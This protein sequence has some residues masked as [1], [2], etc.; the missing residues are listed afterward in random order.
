LLA[1][2]GH[3]PDGVFLALFSGFLACMGGFR[4]RLL[5]CLL[6]SGS[7]AVAAGSLMLAGEAVIST[8]AAAPAHSAG[9]PS[10]QFLARARAA[11]VGYLEANHP[12]PPIDSGVP[13][14][15]TVD[16][17]AKSAPV[18]SSATGSFNW[19]GYADTSTASGTFTEVSGQWKT[20]KVTCTKEDELTAAWVGL[21]GFSNATVEQDGTLGWCFEGQATYFTWWEMYPADLIYVGNSLRP[22]DMIT[23]RVSRTG[24]SYTLSVADATHK[25]NGFS[26][27]QTCGTCDNNSAEWI[28]E[29]PAFGS[30][31][32]APLADYH[33]WTL[34][35]ATE[36]ASGKKGTISSYSPVQKIDMV[37]S[38]DTYV[39]NTT[40]GLTGGSKFTTHW[41]DSY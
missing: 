17:H 22:G 8:A 36:T 1:C 25:G 27:K 32:I 30:T 16:A 31:G 21:D 7:A 29:R 20:P 14:A 28:L 10:A 2:R 41:Q 18:D 23:A 15:P 19:S 3:H 40:S 37:D 9:Q 34:S 24:P 6:I 13:G 38:T 11:L 5:R 4:M 35:N 12:A 33:S 26:V 39:L